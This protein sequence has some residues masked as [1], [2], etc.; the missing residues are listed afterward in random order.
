MSSESKEIMTMYGY[1]GPDTRAGWTELPRKKRRWWRRNEPE[2]ESR[3][4]AARAAERER[5]AAIMRG[6]AR[7]R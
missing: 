5:Q 6:P 4:E 2:Y 3:F 1:S 7:P